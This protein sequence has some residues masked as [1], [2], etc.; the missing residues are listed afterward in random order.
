MNIFL[1]ISSLAMMFT[2]SCQAHNN[3][4]NLRN[5]TNKYIDFIKEFGS[6][7]NGTHDECIEN[8]FSNNLKIIIN[9]NEFHED[10]ASYLEKLKFVK[11]FVNGWDIKICDLCISQKENRSV[12]YYLCFS[13]N[14]CY[15]TICI[16]TFNAIHQITEVN[17][18]YSEKRINQGTW[19]EFIHHSNLNFMFPLFAHLL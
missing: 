1:I 12:I 9:G 11:D 2:F 17:T 7:T 4:D 13:Q 5:A 3:Q 8:L 16:I 19:Y 18:V 15:S 14:S 10:R 6:S